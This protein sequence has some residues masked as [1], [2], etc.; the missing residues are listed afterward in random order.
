MMN[1]TIAM[2]SCLALSL[3][4]MACDL[5]DFL[6]IPK[7]GFEQPSDGSLVTTPVYFEL[8]AKHWDIEPPVQRRD[9]AGYF[10]LILEGG[11]LPAGR[12]V[13]E[14]VVHVFRNAFRTGGH[15]RLHDTPPVASNPV[16][17]HLAQA[18]LEEAAQCME[19]G[20]SRDRADGMGNQSDKDVRLGITYNPASQAGA[21]RAVEAM[22]RPVRR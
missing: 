4:L 18:G 10:V 17:C 11:C 13:M 3:P 22:R 19:T 9:G 5:R 2:T 8:E 1:K 6:P 21:G 16:D 20:D 12:L 15:P 7:V 14:H